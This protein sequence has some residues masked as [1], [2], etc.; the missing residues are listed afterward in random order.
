MDD[1]ITQTLNDREVSYTAQTNFLVQVGHGPK[2]EYKLRYCFTGSLL[3]AVMYYNS[4]NIGRGFKKRL[5]MVEGGKAKTL[6]KAS[7]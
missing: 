4:I 3:Q 2:G 5:Q 1:I 6:C 7:S